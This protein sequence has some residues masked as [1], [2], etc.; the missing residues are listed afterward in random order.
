MFIKNDPQKQWVNGTLGVVTKLTPTKIYVESRSE[1]FD[2]AQA[3]WEKIEYQYNAETD[4]LERIVIGSYTQFPLMLAW[5]ITIHKSQGKTLP[6]IIVNTGGRSFATGQVYVALSRV[7]SLE[8]IQ[9]AHPIKKSEIICSEDVLRFD[10]I[11]SKSSTK[12]TQ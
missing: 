10:E 6:K 8:D 12:N 5:A 9:I 4:K 1:E 3:S 7:R 2:V 11:L